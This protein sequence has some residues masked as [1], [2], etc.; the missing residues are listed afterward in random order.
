VVSPTKKLEFLEEMSQPLSARLALCPLIVK[1]ALTIR[2]LSWTGSPLEGSTYCPRL[3]STVNTS[4]A[5]IP[6]I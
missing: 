6:P 1:V 4:V 5:A 2:E 3:L